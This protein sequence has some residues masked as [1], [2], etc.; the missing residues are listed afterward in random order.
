[1]D[2]YK[3][4]S[5]LLGR[6]FLNS[7]KT[8]PLFNGIIK[9]IEGESCTVD[10][11]GLE[12]DEVRLKATIN[13]ETNKIIVEPKVGSMVLIGSLTGDLK[14]LAVLK[15][16]ELAKIIYQQDGLKLLLD[17]TDGKVSI[18]NNNVSVHD[19]FQQ[20]VDLL[21][22]F[23]VYTPAGPSGTPLPDTITALTAFENDFKLILK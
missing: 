21:K 6:S 11:D 9:S 15:A 2:R 8:M 13:G 23:K 17:S 14:D 18:E 4:L 12:V 20:L 22:L 5:E 10:I 16:D 3:K 19:I 1:M 7:Q